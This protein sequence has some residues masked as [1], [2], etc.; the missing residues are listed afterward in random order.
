MRVPLRQLAHSRSGDKGN[1]VNIAVIAYHPE[2]Y[3]VLEEQLTEAQVHARYQGVVT[4][5]VTRYAVPNLGAL[6]FV[7]EGALGGGVSRSL[8]LD[9]YGKTLAAAVLTIDIELP[10]TLAHLRVGVSGT[11]A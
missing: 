2:L 1:T 3:P 10:D 11:S 7:C 8:C 5:R 6:N 9:N 4:G